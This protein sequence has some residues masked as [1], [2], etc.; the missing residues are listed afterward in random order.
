[1]CFCEQ[2]CFG[3]PLQNSYMKSRA[4]SD[5]ELPSYST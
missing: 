5:T 2:I 1:M 4:S 3:S